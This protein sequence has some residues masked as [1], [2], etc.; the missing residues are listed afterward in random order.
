MADDERWLRPNYRAGWQGFLVHLVGWV[1]VV[2]AN[3]ALVR[4]RHP[5]TPIRPLVIVGAVAVV[6]VAPI[7]FAATNLLDYAI[8]RPYAWHVGPSGI[9]IWRRG[10]VL[11]TYPWSRILSVDR[12]I[13]GLVHINTLDGWRTQ[14]L[15]LLS[16]DD[17]RWLHEYAR[18]RVVERPAAATREA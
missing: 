2:G 9:V 16:R 1:G 3:L 5:E 12:P 14:S 15:R 13:L 8:N 7:L 17:M 4:Y 6:F 10:V 18:D 11:H